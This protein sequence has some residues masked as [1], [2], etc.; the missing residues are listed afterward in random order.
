L[1]KDDEQDNR[2]NNDEKPSEEKEPEEEYEADG[3][4]WEAKY[5][6]SESY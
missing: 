2:P 3:I 6:P 4:D 1:T 5:R